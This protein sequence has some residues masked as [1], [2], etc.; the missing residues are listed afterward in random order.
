MKLNDTNFIVNPHNHCC[1][2]SFSLHFNPPAAEPTGEETEE[3]E[4]PNP[5]VEAGQNFECPVCKNTIVLTDTGDWESVNPE[6][7]EAVVDLNAAPVVAEEPLTT[8][9]SVI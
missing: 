9:V 6:L 1:L 4:A 2:N 8:P 7:T 3:I 5:D